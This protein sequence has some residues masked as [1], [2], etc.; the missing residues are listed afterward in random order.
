MPTVIKLEYCGLITH[1]RQ[2]WVIFVC[3]LASTSSAANVHTNICHHQ[4]LPSLSTDTT[5]EPLLLT[6]VYLKAGEAPWR[7]F[8]ASGRAGRCRSSSPNSEKACKMSCC[9]SSPVATGRD[10]CNV[11][12]LHERVQCICTYVRM[13]VEEQMTTHNT[14]LQHTH[15]CMHAYTQGMVE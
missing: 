13:Y 1:K 9:S 6:C 7:V 2:E 10:S 3:M 14:R 11:A 4:I 8:T 5:R 15:I 12:P